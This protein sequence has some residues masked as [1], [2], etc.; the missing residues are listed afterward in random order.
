MRQLHEPVPRRERPGNSHRHDGAL[1]PLDQERY[2]GLE[3]L[4]LA[5]VRP[6]A[7]GKDQHGLAQAKL[8]DIPLP[9]NPVP[10]LQHSQTGLEIRAG[11]IRVQVAGMDGTEYVFHCYFLGDPNKPASPAQG[12]AAARNL[13]GLTGVVDKVRITFDGKPAGTAAPHGN[14]VVEK[15]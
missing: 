2:P 6:F 7:F 8:L 15:Q 12:A 10:G 13:L 14:L 3:R 5:V 1:H 9:V 11:M 4:H